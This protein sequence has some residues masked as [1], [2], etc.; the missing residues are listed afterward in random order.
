MGLVFSAMSRAGACEERRSSPVSPIRRGAMWR[1]S[2]VSAGHWDGYRLGEFSRILE[3][4]VKI[5]GVK[6]RVASAAPVAGLAVAPVARH[7]WALFVAGVKQFKPFGVWLLR[8]PSFPGLVGRAVTVVM[9]GWGVSVGLGFFPWVLRWPVAVGFFVAVG[10]AN[11]PGG[12]ARGPWH[13]GPA[14]TRALIAAGLLKPVKDGQVQPVAQ[15]GSVEENTAGIAA[16]VRL[17]GSMVIGDVMKSREQLAKALQVSAD[18]LEVSQPASQPAGT[19]EVWIAARQALGSL[20][21]VP[22]PG[23]ARAAFE[24]GSNRRGIPAV[25]PLV[26]RNTAIGGMPGQGKSAL[27]RR[28]ISHYLAD[29]TGRVFVFDGKAT[30]TYAA[31]A[32]ALAR[33]VVPKRA[34]GE[35]DLAEAI[36]ML[37]TVHRIINDHNQRIQANPGPVLVVL[38]EWQDLRTGLSEKEREFLDGL[39]ERCSKKGREANVHV[40][41][42]TQEFRVDSVPNKVRP[43]F[44]NTI[45]FRVR[46]DAEEKLVHGHVLKG[47]KP[48]RPGE[49]ILRTEHGHTFVQADHLTDQAW[50]QVAQRFAPAVTREPGPHTAP[51]SGSQP[52]AAGARMPAQ[53]EPVDQISDITDPLLR[54]T[55]QALE[56]VA[57]PLS[58]SELLELLP[59]AIRPKDAAQLGR[60]LGK[61][62][63]RAERSATGRTYCHSSVIGSVIDSDRL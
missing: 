12:V 48:M 30:H 19:I 36:E 10:L 57:R 2:G 6:D 20:A 9:L 60:E 63:V 45:N 11:Q 16:I 29:P 32:H 3:T 27:C 31:A 47:R 62:G 15:V 46:D 54:F 53:R 1:G 22:V 59:E 44:T 39:L 17:P 14:F 13:T 26:E 5:Q 38:D 55:V 7:G 56:R 24:V 25:L 37:E 50:A 21:V 23:N 28:I 58:A 4:V 35:C 43:Q 41:M 61:F 40:V 8:C 34:T 33:F 52:G 51:D 42:A 49:M 18:D